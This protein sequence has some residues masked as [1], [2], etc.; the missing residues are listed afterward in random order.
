MNSTDQILVQPYTNA[1]LDSGSYNATTVAKN[2]TESTPTSDSYS[3]FAVST[4]LPQLLKTFEPVIYHGYLASSINY[5]F[6]GTVLETG[7]RA[8]TWMTDRFTR[9]FVLTA[10]FESTDPAYEWI[11]AYLNEEKIW[12]SA[13]E[14]RVSARTTS[15]T[16][17]VNSASGTEEK[18]AH[19]EYTPSCD[20]T[21]F[22]WF[23]G[24]WCQVARKHSFA[25]ALHGLGH[26]DSGHLRLTMYTRRREM[27]DELVETAYS[28]YK[29]KPSKP[30]L[31]VHGTCSCGGW[32]KSITKARR[33]IDSLILPNG[34]KEMLLHDTKEFLKSQNWYLDA[35]IQHKRGYLLYGLPGTGKTSTIHALAGEL[36]L[37]IYSLS[38][39]TTSLD[40]TGLSN[41]ISNT[42]ANC[43]ILIE[44]I[45]CAFPRRD[46]DELK[47][48]R[49]KGMI[50]AERKSNITLSGLLNVMDGVSSEEG[51]LI[52]ATSSQTNYVNR[53]DPAFLRPGR[54]DVKIHYKLSTRDQVINLFKR[55]YS[56]SVTS[57][58]SE[59]TP[60]TMPECPDKEMKDVDY[61]PPPTPS[62]TST[63]TPSEAS[64][65]HLSSSTHP[66]SDETEL[67]IDIPVY[68]P[69]LSEST[70]Q[71]L[72]EQFADSIPQNK[73]S[74]AE[75]QGYLLTVKT[76][77][78]HAVKGVAEWMKELQEEK[79]RL[80]REEQR[81][82]LEQLEREERERKEREEKQAKEK[83]V[84]KGEEIV[85]EKPSSD[86]E[87]LPSLRSPTSEKGVVTDLD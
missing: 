84:A 25:N 2:L 42:P 29:I 11:L 47:E 68:P 87:V 28:Q 43:I 9:S 38:L 37:E 77:P 66:I 4:A 22:F 75:L 14:F 6:F 1:T 13:R 50:I 36:D 24:T 69:R 55:F 65:E 54:M 74:M 71:S 33:P 58:G 62:R 15:R 49:E 30:R 63:R 16:W 23:R 57:P 40:D 41:L 59:V 5:F 10:I 78:F 80:V 26:E 60:S 20:Q 79:E 12:S 31:V 64:A 35:G 27:L 18:D 72:A 39:A 19:A 82:Q 3:A 76:R 83:E 32:C 73:F 67:N 70:L 53:L 34:V 52:F 86:G 81:E 17:G 51:R 61:T 46:E 56:M 21:Q 48:L 45:D 7:R 85:D 8:W 44:D